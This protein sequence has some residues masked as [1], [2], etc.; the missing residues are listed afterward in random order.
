MM[1]GIV[2]VIIAM[3]QHYNISQSRCGLENPTTPQ[4]PLVALR[5]R[6]RLGRNTVT[7]GRNT[8]TGTF[9]PALMPPSYHG[10]C[11]LLKF[12]G[13]PVSRGWPSPLLRYGS[14]FYFRGAGMTR[15]LQS[16]EIHKTGGMR[17]TVGAKPLRPMPRHWN[18]DSD[19]PR[20]SA[21]CA[22]HLMGLVCHLRLQ[23]L[24]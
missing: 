14:S 11:G 24:L 9:A 23:C 13:P 19:S 10:G 2:V 8:M 12:F 3:V 17:H 1:T 7:G 4:L 21:R 5:A 18:F 20:A 6:Q 16:S 15:R 22:S